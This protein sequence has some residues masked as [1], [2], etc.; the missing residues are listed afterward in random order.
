[1]LFNVGERGAWLRR[2]QEALVYQSELRLK[3]DLAARATIPAPVLEV[4]RLLAD[5]KDVWEGLALENRERLLPLEH[6][7]LNDI[8]SSVAQKRI[9]QVVHDCTCAL[10]VWLD[11]RDVGGRRSDLMQYTPANAGRTFPRVCF[12]RVDACTLDCG[13]ACLAQRAVRSRAPN[14]RKSQS[15]WKRLKRKLVSELQK[16][17][18]RRPRRGP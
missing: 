6:S 17:R 18:H 5:E 13:V 3:E 14:N 4:W 16:K 11:G 8:E 1:M 7:D 2:N 12:T 15:S 9:R 10:N